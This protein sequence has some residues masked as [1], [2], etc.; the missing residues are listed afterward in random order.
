MAI[1]IENLQLLSLADRVQINVSLMF[2][3]PLYSLRE[4][5]EIKLNNL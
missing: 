3:K 5:S 2:M 4:K 1:K